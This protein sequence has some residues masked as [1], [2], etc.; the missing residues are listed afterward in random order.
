MYQKVTCIDLEKK[1]M[2]NIV[3][4]KGGDI[5]GSFL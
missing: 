5:Y 1:E 2:Y 3:T 4:L